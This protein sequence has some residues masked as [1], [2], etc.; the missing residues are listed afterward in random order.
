MPRA[1]AP[2]Y[3]LNGGEVG[4]E[5]LARLDLERLQFAGSLYSNMLPRVIGSM[6]L[7]PGLEHIADIDFGDVQ[8]IEYAYSGGSTLI[9]ILSDDGMRVVAGG[10]VV[11]RNSVSTVIQHGGFFS[12]GGWD[13]I[14][15]GDAHA[16]IISDHLQLI[17][18]TQNYAEIRQEVPVTVHDRKIEHGLRVVVLRGPVTVIVGTGINRDDL[19]YAPNLYD[20]E[21]SFAF[22]PGAGHSSIFVSLSGAISR[23][24][25]VE[26]CQIEGPG[27][28]IIP[29]PWTSSD[30]Q[31]N[32]V[33]YKQH[34]DV[35]Y[36]ASRFYQQREIQRRGDRSWGVQRYVVDDGP[37]ISSDGS[38]SLTVSDYTGGIEITSN[39]RYFEEGMVGR[40]FRIFH[41]GQTV[42][43]DFASD[44][45]EGAYVRISGVGDDREIVYTVSGT[46]T[47]VVNLEVAIDDGSGNPSSWTLLETIDHNVTD[48]SY[49]DEDDNVIKYIRFVLY[50]GDL[51][52]GTVS[53]KIVYN[54]GSQSGVARITAFTDA[55]HVTAEVIK[56]FYSTKASF[57]WDYSVW[58]DFDGWPAAVETFGGRLYWGLGDFIYGSV[59]D[60]YHSFD[61]GVDGDS[62]PISRSIGSNTQ[63][64]SLWLLGLQRLICGID[65]SEISIKSS[66]F[67]EP[68]TAS[69]W[70]PIESS[71]RGSFDIRAVKADR[72]G[73]FVQTSGTAAFRLLTDQGTLDYTS[74]DLTAMNEEICDGYEIVD[75]AVQRRPDTIVWFVLANGEAR[76]LTYEP[77]ENV[78]A[79]SRVVTDGEFKR[80]CCSK[81]AG[82]DEVYFAVVRNGTQ[83]LE[84]L[85]ALK[86]CK[87]GA[88]NC[89]ADAFSR[90]AGANTIFNVPHL[91]GLDVTVWANGVA[92]HDQDNLYH[93][94]GGV[95]TLPS[96]A[97]NVVIGL[98]YSGQ[99]QSVK[100]AYAAAG[101][102]AL[103][104][105]KRIAQL[106]LY[107]TKTMLDGFRAGNSFTNLRKFTVA[108][109]DKVIP[110]GQLQRTFDADLMPISSD[111]GTDSRICIEA[112]SPYP[113]TVSAVVFDETT[114][115]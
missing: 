81:S 107:L 46:W 8:L 16:D 21:H 85:A 45:A 44:P 35:I 110:P 47:G 92:I 115:G 99:W 104:Q 108:K 2:L 57:D 90:F 77:V 54:G 30:I 23:I 19:V 50:T 101:G 109:G 12:L 5:A 82:Q 36:S 79:W 1:H 78:I 113:C 40:L 53:T 111:W 93:V 102:T 83:R 7:R 60:N 25:S 33:R 49:A 62:A 112:K 61:D 87:G 86:D 63:R 91:D 17:G 70:F 59:P 100:L 94:T 11:S 29:T 56:R 55:R 52:S 15:D 37:F 14:S 51:N 65:T 76:A 74:S 88:I 43:E 58:S 97:S 10:D 66:S 96:A 3:S 75:I 9:P 80:V 26:Q 64:G 103:F 39:S 71:T 38:I 24:A 22:T 34:K 13:D 98:P 84:R 73:I 114:N 67:D 20:G 42:I 27:Q 4:E 28:M 95:V 48:V 31:Q 18:T 6:T 41:S 32:V 72:D 89:I 105:K 69:A 68:L 106:G